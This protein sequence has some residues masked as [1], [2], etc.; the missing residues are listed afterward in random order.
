[1]NPPIEDLKDHLEDNTDLV[2][3]TDLFLGF[4]PPEVNDCVAL[5]DI[6]GQA[7]EPTGIQIAIVQVLVRGSVGKYKA[8]YSIIETVLDELHGLAN[9]SINGTLYIDVWK[10]Q[11]VSALGRDKNGRPMF[12]CSL[13]VQRSA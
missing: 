8:A 10:Q 3:G 11:E 2:L 9:T 5:F 7:P 1:M 12:T 13:R 6:T 4:L